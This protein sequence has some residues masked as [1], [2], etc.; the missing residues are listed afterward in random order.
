MTRDYKN[1]GQ[2]T[3]QQEAPAVAGWVWLAIGFV[4]GFG[5]AMGVTWLQQSETEL[6]DFALEPPPPPEETEDS[7][8]NDDEE[9]FSFYRMLESFEVSVPETDVDLRDGREEES[10]VPEL[11]EEG[12]WLLQVASFS[13][14][15]DA[16]R[17][18]ANL[19]LAGYDAGIN[20]VEI[21]DGQTYYRVHV[22]P[23]TDPR[24]VERT[25]EQLEDEG[26]EPLILRGD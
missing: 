2:A 16:D 21:E 3:R 26:M 8:G 23:I 20:R 14:E 5:T 17:M 19:T 15:A 1:A 9:G 11:G 25:L 7:D 4:L 24:E 6:P 12:R 22:G 13:S 10:R 18:R